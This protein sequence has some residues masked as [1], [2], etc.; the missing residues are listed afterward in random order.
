MKPKEEN[1]SVI[2]NIVNYIVNNIVIDNVVRGTGDSD[3]VAVTGIPAVDALLTLRELIP[4]DM[5]VAFDV[6]S[7]LHVAGRFWKTP[8]IEKMVMT[9]GWSSMGFAI[10]AANAIA[11]NDEG[12]RAVAILGDGCFLMRAGEVMTAR[13]YNLNVVYFILNDNELNL[14]RVKQ[15]WQGSKSKAT[16]LCEGDFFGADTFLGI[17][18]FKAETEKELRKAVKRALESEGPVIVNITIDPEQY[19]SVISRQ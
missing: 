18:L 13:R 14:I 12:G 17:P 1:I 9:N 6:G 4:E 10:P 15:G 7:H 5:P 8:G 3:A 11:L 2:N 16:S 19:H